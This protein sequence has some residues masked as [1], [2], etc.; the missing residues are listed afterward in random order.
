MSNL[1]VR[2]EGP[3]P[4]DFVDDWRP[5]SAKALPDDGDDTPFMP[6]MLALENVL[7]ELFGMVVAVHPG[8]GLLP[9]APDIAPEIGAMLASM[10]LGG[11]AA[12]PVPHVSGL[13][14]ARHAGLIA[15]ILQPTVLQL[16]P[17]EARRPALIVDVVVTT[18][19]GDPVVG[20]MRLPAPAAPVP[21]VPPQPLGAAGLQLPMR[22][23]VR[24]AEADVPLARL[25]PLRPGLVISFDICAEMPVL[26]GDHRL[27]LATL[28][29]LADG[30]QQASIVALDLKPQGERI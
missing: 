2:T 26:L 20:S 13:T 24:L 22:L 10:R 15:Q 27:A 6:L 1:L 29:P 3:P 7:G 18:G 17:P 4:Q 28:M 12:R 21:L 19:T 8:R 23:A 5:R 9:G 25:L 30:R 14:T 16:W 11:D